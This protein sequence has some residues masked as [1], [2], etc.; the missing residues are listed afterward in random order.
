MQQSM[1]Y[2]VMSWIRVSCLQMRMG[3][4]SWRTCMHAC[5]LSVLE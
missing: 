4:K 2:C 1:T 5:M 3:L